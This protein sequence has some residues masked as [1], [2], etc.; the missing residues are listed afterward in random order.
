MELLK[1][2]VEEPI[3]EPEEQQEEMPVEEELPEPEETIIEAP[4]ELLDL[5]EP[6]GEV[7][8]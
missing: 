6:T 4:S 8:E 5:D 2:K 1:E 3:T 7:I